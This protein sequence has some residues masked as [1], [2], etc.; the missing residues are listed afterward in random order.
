MLAA[1]GFSHTPN[2]TFGGRPNPGC[3]LVHLGEEA[4]AR[5]V[6]YRSPPEE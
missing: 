6:A 5:A 2:V 3:V 1:G 4:K